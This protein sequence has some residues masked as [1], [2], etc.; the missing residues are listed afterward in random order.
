MTASAIDT[1]VPGTARRRSRGKSG[2]RLPAE[3]PAWLMHR[4]YND[5]NQWQKTSVSE[6]A[7]EYSWGSLFEAG[8]DWVLLGE[9][10]V[11]RQYP[12][13]HP[14][15]EERAS[16]FTVAFPQESVTHRA[17]N[18]RRFLAVLGVLEIP[19]RPCTCSNRTGPSRTPGSPTSGRR[20][21]TT[22]RSRT[23]CG[24]ADRALFTSCP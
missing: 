5:E 4:T 7:G 8:E 22:T 3:T 9:S 12:T 23:R 10:D 17:T 24:I 1:D 20:S 15:I 19:G 6:A 21:R 13:T 16:T 2:F 11:R 18:R 14:A